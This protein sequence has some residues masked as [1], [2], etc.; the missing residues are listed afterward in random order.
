MSLFHRA[1]KLAHV[2]LGAAAVTTA[3]SFLLSGSRHTTS[4]ATAKA[5]QTASRHFHFTAIAQSHPRRN[6]ISQAH[7]RRFFSSATVKEA[8]KQTS[9]KSSNNAAAAATPK[10]ETGSAKETANGGFVAWYEGH[11]QSRPIATKAVTGSLLWG[12]GNA[13]AQIVPTM[14]EEDKDT[15]VDIQHAIELYDYPRTA[16]AMFFGFAIHAPLSHVHF[17]FLEWMTVRGG[18][19]GLSIPVFKTVMEQVSYIWI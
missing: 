12:L 17:N 5:S 2:P 6:G 4:R 9:A 8:T 11:L 19:T 7:Q 10:I 1:T 16:R 14:L 13:V 18:F 15:S 3:T